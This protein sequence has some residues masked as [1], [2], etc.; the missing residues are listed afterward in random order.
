[1]HHNTKDKS[2]ET[3]LKSAFF[4]EVIGQGTSNKRNFIFLNGSLKFMS[5][6]L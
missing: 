1:M 4:K 6:R 2:L 3:N 5:M